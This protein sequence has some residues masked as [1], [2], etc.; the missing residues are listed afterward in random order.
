MREEK[1]VWHVS[2]PDGA[3]TALTDDPN[4]YEGIAVSDKGRSVITVAINRKVDAFLLDYSNPNGQPVQLTFGNDVANGVAWTFDNRIVYSSTAS[5][6]SDVWIMNSDGGGARQLTTDSHPDV[7]PV[8]S[9][10]NRF[11]VFVSTRSGSRELWRMDLNGANQLQLTKGAAANTPTVT[12]DGKSVIYYTQSER[13]GSLFRVSI[14]GGNPELIAVGV[15]RYPAASLDGKWLLASCRPNGATSNKICTAS[16]SDV[17]TF[18]R[19]YE[20]VAGANSPSKMRWIGSKSEAF[21]Y[22]VNNRGVENLWEQPIDGG[23]AKKITDFNENY[24]YAFDWSPDGKKLVCG[25]GNTNNAAVL[26]SLKN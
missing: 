21:T 26:F 23:S 2:Y 19:I 22:I 17:S 16:L 6:N 18:A 14:D 1:Q 12:A 3:A 8:V 4:D 10:D 7:Q 11:V 5:G 15:R 20:P 9:P 25:R 13:G 24:F